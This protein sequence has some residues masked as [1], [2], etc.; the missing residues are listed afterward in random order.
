MAFS[1][2]GARAPLEQSSNHTPTRSER[3]RIRPPSASALSLV[4]TCTTRLLRSVSYCQ[5]K[6]KLGLHAGPTTRYSIDS[7]RVNPASA[8]CVTDELAGT[9]R[10]IAWERLF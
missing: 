6:F 9:D 7:R 10:A 8:W 1:W 2:K 3:C 5:N 4:L